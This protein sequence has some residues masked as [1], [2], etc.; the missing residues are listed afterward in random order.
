MRLVSHNPDVSEVPTASIRD[1][2]GWVI[3]RQ[4]EDHLPVA[5]GTAQVTR[6]RVPVARS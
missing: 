3:T 5:R 1:V 4:G 2:G 6:D